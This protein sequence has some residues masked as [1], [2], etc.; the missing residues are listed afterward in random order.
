[1][2]LGEKIRQ[3]R[4]CGGLSQGQLAEKICVSRSAIAKWETDKGLPDVENLKLLAR[5]LHVSVDSL[6]EDRE[7]EGGVLIRE[8]YDP[9]GL[10]RGCERVRKDRLMVRR[11]P[12]AR[13]LS[14]LGRPQFA[15]EKPVV[16]RARGFLTR[17]P[18]G[19]AAYVKSV[20][21]Q[22]KAFYLVEQEEEQY[23]VT[24]GAEALEIR[25]L[26][27]RREGQRFTLGTWDFVCMK[28]LSDE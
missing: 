3:A 22:E 26:S 24:V 9:E 15:G 10:G 16:N 5:L 17:D 25:P 20:R 27:Q 7:P 18:F 1:M 23:F 21:E 14:L 12:G 19:N 13:I 2:T 11:F 28:E 6:L 8:A 4:R